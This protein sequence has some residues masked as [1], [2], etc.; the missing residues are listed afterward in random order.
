LYAK[1]AHD[2]SPATRAAALVG[3][4]RSLRKAGRA[5]EAIDAYNALEKLGDVSVAGRPAELAAVEGRC[6]V[7]ADMRR[8]SDLRQEAERLDLALWSGRWQLSRSAWEFQREQAGR[9]GARH[10]PDSRQQQAFALSA[11]VHTASMR[12]QAEP[13]RSGQWSPDVEGQPSLAVWATQGLARTIVVAGPEWLR[14]AWSRAVNGQRVEGA[15]NS[16][17]RRLAAG[18]PPPP[19]GLRAVRGMEST[20]LPWSVAVF[21]SDP[22]ADRALFASRRRLLVTTFGVLGL[23]LLAG[24]FF[25]LRSIQRE[26]D[27]ARMQTEFVSAVSHEFRTPLTSLGQLSEMLSKGRVP[28]DALKQDAYEILARETDRLR[29][30]VESILDFGRI[31][32]GSYRYELATLDAA[33]VVREVVA[34]L[35]PQA[36]A[37]GFTI[38]VACP[39]DPL[40]VQADRAALSLALRNLVD[41]A[42]KYSG[43]SRTVWVAADRRGDRVC[44]SVR[45]RGAGIPPAEQ[46]AIYRKFVRGAAA[47]AAGVAGVGIGLAIASQIVTAHRGRIALDSEPGAGSTFTI[48]L[49]STVSGGGDSG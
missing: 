18:A 23:A 43:A 29:R 45:D 17:S 31:E 26:R 34:E 25:I 8:T 16:A 19:D 4:G 46:R 48:E 15:L 10:Q 5:A 36:A 27:V 2:P 12:L 7:L 37:A 24:S 47:R 21:P 41:N 49:P 22:L 38:D 33:A 9:W 6:S 39:P 13:G 3:L 28:T 1:L 42:I 30:L 35:E 20:G 40:A 14:A 32:A 11:A 44:L